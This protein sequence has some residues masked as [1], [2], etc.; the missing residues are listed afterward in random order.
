MISEEPVAGDESW[1]RRGAEAA[2]RAF[3]FKG[4]RDEP[5]VLLALR[6]DDRPFDALARA[7]DIAA[8]LNGS[9]HVVRVH[10]T[11]PARVDSMRTSDMSHAAQAARHALD[12]LRAT[13]R[14]L[15]HCLD[16]DMPFHR[17]RVVHGDFNTVVAHHAR[18]L[19]AALV[20]VSGPASRGEDV[21][22]IA[23][24][25]RAPVLSAHALTGSSVFVAG[26]SLSDP[27]LP[28]LKRASRFSHAL[29]ATLVAVH[30][31]RGLSP[32]AVPSTGGPLG[33]GAP[34]EPPSSPAERLAD[35]MASVEGQRCGVVLYVEDPVDAILAVAREE[36][37]DLVFVGVH[38][39]SAH[40]RDSDVA[41][42]V[43][44]RARRSVVV[45]PCD[46]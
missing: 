17:I 4:I 27:R 8:A 9:L 24:A 39:S 6:A 25:S 14:W 2:L 7:A 30:G 40:P 13:Q 11:E 22:A 12:S 43:V 33:L 23:A 19:G 15:E 5:H 46:V 21:A 41:A 3:V 29:D 10:S 1:V 34:V 31:V 36:D 32:D 42:S 38:A 44:D 28:V 20:V 26:T 16:V 45:T 37:A 18:T 35:A